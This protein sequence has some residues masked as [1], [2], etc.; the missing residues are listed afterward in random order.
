MYKSPGGPPCRAAVAFAGH[1]QMGAAVHAGGNF[2]LELL[3]FPE[4]AFTVTV[5]A[6]FGSKLLHALAPGTGRGDLKDAVAA[7]DHPGR[8]IGDRGPVWSRA[9]RRCRCRCQVTTRGTSTVTSVPRAASRKSRVRSYRRSLPCWGRGPPPPKPPP[10]P[11]TSPK[12]SLKERKISEKS[13]KPVNPV[14]ERPSWP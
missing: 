1:D 7:G 8:R 12:I 10:K 4:P 6:G 9:W 5:G 13:R 3:L 11:K 2:H 14:E